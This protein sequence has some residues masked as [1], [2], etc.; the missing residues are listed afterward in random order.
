MREKLYCHTHLLLRTFLQ[1]TFAALSAD[2]IESSFDHG[3]IAHRWLQGVI[4]STCLPEIMARLNGIK[5]TKT[6]NR[7]SGHYSADLSYVNAMRSAI[8]NVAIDLL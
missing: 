2:C 3:P 8:R 7:V 1:W 4:M 5:Q 6:R